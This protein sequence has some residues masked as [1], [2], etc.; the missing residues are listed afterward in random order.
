MTPGNC[1]EIVNALERASTIDEIQDVFSIIC[2]YLDQERSERIPIFPR[3]PRLASRDGYCEAWIDHFP[4]HWRAG[5]IPFIRFCRRNIRLFHRQGLNSGVGEGHPVRQIIDKARAVGPGE[6]TGQQVSDHLGAEASPF[7]VTSTDKKEKASKWN[8]E[9]LP[10]ILLF[11]ACLREG[12]RR[13]VI[14]DPIDLNKTGLTDREKEC[15]FWAAEGKTSWETAKILQISKRTIIFHLQNATRKLNAVNRQ[16]A[17][18]RAVVLGLV[19][20]KMN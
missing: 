1:Q 2:N 14:S 9:T 20:P 15:L 17:I 8:L 12:N 3:S 7:P 4:G 5:L 19:T 18:A 13:A 10:L 16:N 11:Y 6:D